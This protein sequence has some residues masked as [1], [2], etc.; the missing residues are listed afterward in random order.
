MVALLSSRDGEATRD[1][2]DAGAATVVAAPQASSP[3]ARRPR[4]G[5]FVCL[6]YRTLDD[7]EMSRPTS[8]GVVDLCLRVAYNLVY[9]SLSMY[10]ISSLRSFCIVDTCILI[11]NR[12]LVLLFDIYCLFSSRQ[13]KRRWT[14]NVRVWVCS[15]VIAL[16]SIR[17]TFIQD[18]T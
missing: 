16:S 4:K 6:S 12:T 18:T 10:N 2:G 17:M 15:C 7:R 3:D 1:V 13:M 9:N 11:Y 5:D 8:H 14:W